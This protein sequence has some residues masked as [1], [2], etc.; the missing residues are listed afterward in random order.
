MPDLSVVLEHAAAGA[1]AELDLD[2]IALRAQRI[3]RHRRVSHVVAAGT[4]TA[5]LVVATALV[6]RPGTPTSL[7]QRVTTPVEQSTSG[8]SSPT[9]N[10]PAATAGTTGSPAP[11][12]DC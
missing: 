12:V 6:L 1:H 8:T 7:D 11:L 9:P 5:A 4:A 3:R 2:D 10:Q